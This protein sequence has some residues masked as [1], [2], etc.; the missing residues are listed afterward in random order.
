MLTL[1]KNLDCYT[2]K[3]IGKNDILICSDK[4]YKLQP[5][6]KFID[7]NIIENVYDFEGLNAFP[8][9]IDQHVH[10]TGGGGEEG[11]TG[12][13][14]EINI[15]HILNAGVTTL[16][17]LLGADSCS[18]SL[19]SLYV[20][21]KSL[22]KQGLTTYI[23]SGSYT[24]PPVTFT[25][26]IVRDLVLIDKV[27]GVGEIAISDHR[28]SHATINQLLKIASDSHL[29]GLL[30]GK[31]GVIH[32]HVGNGKKG[33]YP[34]LQ[35]LD[36]SDLP[37]EQFIPTHLNRNSELFEQAMEYC[38]FG[39]N[40]D[41]TSGETEGI[42]VSEAIRKLVD[43]EINLS[44]VTVSSDANGSIPNGGVSS[45]HTLLDDIVSCII[46][47]EINPETAISLVTENVSKVLKLYPRKGTLLEGSDADILITGKNYQI[48]K[49]FCSGKLL[50]DK[51]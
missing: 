43:E 29:G 9:F 11:F 32:L 1:L 15:N 16:V 44:K 20:K 47:K 37:I 21:A 51:R 41:L 40:I 4:I 48:K 23:Y 27:I 22:E 35:M 17:G 31:A 30:S 18:R 5:Q 39:G 38:K 8:G 2:P 36:K 26:D 45:I 34:L 3:Y 6:I 12:H 25:G 42:S 10:I 28:S 49:V 24:V 19:E 14:S 46:D 13:I 33:L 7:K 50:K